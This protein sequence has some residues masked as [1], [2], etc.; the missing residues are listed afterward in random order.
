[1]NY[2]EYSLPDGSFSPEYGAFAVFSFFMLFYI[3][4]AGCLF[5]FHGYLLLA[6][7]TSRELLRRRKCMYLSNVKGNP[8]F[9][10]LI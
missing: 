6:N 2:F 3:G 5:A 1:M 10:G 9:K 7:I 8:F 4:F